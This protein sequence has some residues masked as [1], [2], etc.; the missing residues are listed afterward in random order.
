M[1]QFYRFIARY[2]GKTYL[3]DLMPKLHITLN[4]YVL[5]VETIL[6]VCFRKGHLCRKDKS[7][8]K[9]NFRNTRMQL[10]NHSKATFTFTA[11]YAAK[12]F[13]TIMQVQAK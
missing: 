1:D 7:S 10:V 4:N 9:K 13:Y 8:K 2:T 3:I 5:V 12:M 6:L 11:E